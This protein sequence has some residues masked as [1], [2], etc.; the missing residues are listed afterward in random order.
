MVRPPPKSTRTDTLCPYPTLFRSEFPTDQLSRVERDAV[1][2]TRQ[3]LDAHLGT[4][5]PPT[6]TGEVPGGGLEAHEDAGSHLIER[7]VGRTEQQLLDRLQRENISA[8]S[9]F[10][11]LPAAE[12]FVSGTI[13][14]NQDRVD[15][16]LDGK[17]GTR[18]E[19]G[20]AHV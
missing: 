3:A 5:D 4:V 8:S 19:I 16:W 18:L 15:A 11:D 14:E 10:R 2:S 7:H 12:H 6:D 9:S 17:G 13:S 1:E 20:R